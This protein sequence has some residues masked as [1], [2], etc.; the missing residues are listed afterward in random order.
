MNRIGMKTAAVCIALSIFA[1]MAASRSY[2][3]PSINADTTIAELAAQREENEKLI[4]Q[5]EAELAGYAES[6]KEEEAYQATLQNKIDTLQANMQILDTELE[7]L[8]ENIYNLDLA[9]ADL[10]VT[11]AQ[12]KVDIDEGLEQFKLRLRAMY[13]NG[14]DS[15][16][17]ALVG[18]TDFYDLLSKYEMISC[19]ARHD[20]ELV[21]ELKAELEAYNTNLATLETQK[22]ELEQSKADADAKRVEMEASMEDLQTT[23]QE[24]VAEQQRL[25]NE[26]AA[27]EK[28]IEE[29][30]AEN[31]QL[32]KDEQDILDAIK[33][34]EEEQKRKEEEEQKRKEEEAQQNQNQGGGSSDGSSGGST[35]SGSSGTVEAPSYSGE[36]FG[37]PC[38]GH[39]YISSYYGYRWGRLH[40]G[41]DIANN[42]GA[43]IVASRGGTVIAVSTGCSHNYAK[44]GNCCG[45]GYGNYVLISHN[46]GTFSTMYAHM[47]AVYVSVGESVGKGQ[48]LGTVGCTGYSTG[49]HLHFEIRKNGSAVNPGDYLNY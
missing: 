26:K 6:E 24:S 4:E 15:L 8:K 12:Q 41:Y 20:D 32:E 47:D 46:D 33:R 10:E 40:K 5:Y 25:A 13:V 7:T 31:E 35:D 19:V 2:E 3:L 45:N 30:N 11:I 17:S 21:N 9:I 27:R 42:A 37:W 29:L 1:G 28:S 36:S 18:A 43:T 22:A 48:A 39:Y 38:P 16:A 34:A 49:F 23:Y 44:S 14:N